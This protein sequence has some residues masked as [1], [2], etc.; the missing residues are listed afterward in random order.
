[1]CTV[2]ASTDSSRFTTGITASVS[3]II[4]EDYVNDPFFEQ[5][6]R[7]IKKAPFYKVQLIAKALGC[8]ME[9]IT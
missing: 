7:D 2:S 1:M 5:Q 8:S 4:S 3:T 9:D 6:T